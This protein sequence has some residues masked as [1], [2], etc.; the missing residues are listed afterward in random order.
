MSNFENTLCQTTRENNISL[1]A[2]QIK[3]FCVLHEALLDIDITWDDACFARTITDC[4]SCYDASVFPEGGYMLDA[5]SGFGFPGIPLKIVHPDLHMMFLDV[6]EQR[7]SW[8]HSVLEKLHMDDIELKISSVQ[9]AAC[10]GNYYG[11]YDVV[12]SR[13]LSY[14]LK[15]LVSFCLPFLKQG[16]YYIPFELE[17][18]RHQIAEA[19][20]GLESSGGKIEMLR[21]REI[22]S[23][24][25]VYVRK[26]QNR[27]LEDVRRI[28]G[29]F[30]E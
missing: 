25:F 15:D 5:A 26:V 23:R 16:G 21:E 3:Q 29:A 13:G 19:A 1:T 6:Y 18:T 20:E 10:E 4:L 24:I 22:E 7:L 28:I 17:R 14:E 30:Q 12:T 8:W 27:S 11:W 2:D 9:D